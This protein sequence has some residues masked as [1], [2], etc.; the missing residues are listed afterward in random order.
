MPNNDDDEVSR[1]EFMDRLGAGAVL[2]ATGV[3]RK[4]T[5]HGKSHGA[6]SHPK[7]A[8][9]WAPPQVAKNP[10]ILLII[11]DQFRLPTWMTNL[12]PGQSL[13]AT[14]PNLTAL[15]NSSYN[16]GEYFVAATMCT[17][18]RATLL[19]GLYAPQ[20]G[21]YVNQ[22]N[23]MSP[24]LNPAFPTWGKALPALNPAYSGNMWWFGKWHLSQNLNSAPLAQYGFKTRTYPGGPTAPFNYSPDGFPNEGSDGGVAPNGEVWASDSMIAGDFIGWLQGQSPTVGAPSTPWCATVSLI[25]PHDIASAPAWLQSNPF[26]PKGVP[27]NAVYFPPPPFPLTDAGS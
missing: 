18:S 19:T 26:P 20:T 14:L 23:P 6:G 24:P 16:F 22:D 5:N 2:A 17:P 8:P 10:N 3:G 13:A 9:P 15:Q 21:V 4:K 11:V 25:N 1:R 7:S 27:K 12:G